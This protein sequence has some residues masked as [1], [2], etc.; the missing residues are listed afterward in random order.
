M[1]QGVT[2]IDNF[3]EKRDEVKESIFLVRYGFLI[4]YTELRDEIIRLLP[5]ESLASIFW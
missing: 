3:I 1:F 5:L 2:D 4:D